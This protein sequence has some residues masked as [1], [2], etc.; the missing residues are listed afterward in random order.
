MTEKQ[1]NPNRD[2][3][4]WSFDHGVGRRTFLAAGGGVSATLLA[5]CSSDSGSES[6][7]GD[8]ETDG[9]TE[10]D[11]DDGAA[12]TFRLLIS[13]MP[14]DIGDFDRLDVALDSA[15]IFD[16]EGEDAEEEDDESDDANEG[17]DERDGEEVDDEN[18]EEND[19]AN[20][21][22]EERDTE[23]DDTEDADDEKEETEDDE[24][25]GFYVVDLEGATVDL[26]QVVG[27]K[28]MPVGELDLSEGTYQK[29]ELHVA[30]VEG[31]VDGDEANVKVPSEKLQLTKPFEVRAGE[32]VDFVFDINVVKRG[33]G[34]DYNLTPVIS[35]SGIKGEDVEVEE[36]PE[37]SESEAEDGDEEAGDEGD[38]DNDEGD[39]GDQDDEDNEDN[40]NEETDEKG[41]E[42]ETEDG[43]GN[44]G[45]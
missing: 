12:G 21:E 13:D 34:N 27:D 33:Q 22:E 17:E 40:E 6:A 3:A 30:D 25:R 35:K 24:E 41:N 38:G 31:I 42:S 9:S 1:S 8:D 14:A 37:G 5:G 18:E 44:D 11:D 43:E 19:T 4:D 10:T 7:D 23:K 15:R 29:I 32:S 36:V 20:G 45:T 39:E 28:A 2:R 26:T 16:G